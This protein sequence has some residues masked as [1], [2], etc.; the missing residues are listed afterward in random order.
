MSEDLHNI[1]DLFRSALNKHEDDPPSS[2]VWESIDKEN[3]TP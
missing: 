1:D 2:G 3:T